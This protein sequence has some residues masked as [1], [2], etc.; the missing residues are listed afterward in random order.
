MSQDDSTAYAGLYDGEIRYMDFHLGKFFE[1]LRQDQVLDRTVL[2]ITADHGEQ[3]GEQGYLG[4]HFSLR[5]ALIHVP[6]IIR[7]PEVFPRGVRVQEKVQTMDILPT[8]LSLLDIDD[9]ALWAPLLGQSLYPLPRRERSTIIAE[10]FRSFLEMKFVKAYQPDF[11]VDEV[12]GHRKTACIHDSYKYIF[13]DNGEESLYHLG[14]DARETRNLV[15]ALPEI[16]ES[17]RGLLVQ[18]AGSFEPYQLKSEEFDFQP[19]PATEEQ[20][21]SL[22][23]IQ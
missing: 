14:Q 1:Q 13:S 5:E 21:R 20:L 12:Y 3:I 10:E 2:I 6:L 7:Y 18:W 16:L 8:I 19:D 11:D 23:Y 17:L 9:Q 15:S 4:H 22:G